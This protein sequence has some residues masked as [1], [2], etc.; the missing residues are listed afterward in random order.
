VRLPALFGK[1]IKKN[2]IYDLMNIVPSMLKADIIKELAS[3]E[4]IIAESYTLQNSGFY[5]CVE[6]KNLDQSLM[7]AFERLHFSALN[8]TDSRASY[9]FYNLSYLWD[10]I[11]IALH[12]NLSLVNLAVEPI[13]V[14]ELYFKVK[15]SVFNNELGL[16]FNKYDFKSV[17]ADLYSGSKGYLFPKS[18]VMNDICEFIQGEGRRNV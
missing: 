10:H 1:H 18:K 16:H 9:Q 17:F 12:N 15:G 4:S 14:S 3:K 13:C 2:F 11:Q 5:K 6:G 8:F 7:A